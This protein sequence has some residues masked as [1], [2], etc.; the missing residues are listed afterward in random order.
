M[1]NLYNLTTN[2]DAMRRFKAAIQRELPLEWP[3]IRKDWDGPII[4][5]TEDGERVMDVM[6]FG[7]PP[8]RDVDQRKLIANVRNTA[9]PHWRRWLKC[10]HRCLVPFTA[11]CEVDARRQPIWFELNGA[12]KLAAFAGI[13][14]EGEGEHLVANPGQS[15][16]TRQYR[17]DW[18]YYGFLT[19]DPNAVVAPH[20]PKAMPVILTAED[21]WDLWLDG[22]DTAMALALQ[23]PLGDEALNVVAG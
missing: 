3:A 16:R 9:S 8:R 22:E 11:F 13:W 7:L 17:P 21:E 23:R 2:Q 20:H 4:R 19:T 15:R 18:R 14:H 6:R 5:R 10:G 12:D 1:C